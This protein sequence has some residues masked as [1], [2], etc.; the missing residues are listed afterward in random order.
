FQVDSLGERLDPHWHRTYSSIHPPRASP[1]PAR[2]RC[3]YVFLCRSSPPEPNGLPGAGNRPPSTQQAPLGGARI[4]SIT[5]ESHDLAC[6]VQLPSPT[7]AADLSPGQDSA[8]S[9]F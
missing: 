1:T 6:R 3:E 5:R 9:R 7:L 2:E 8:N 4:R